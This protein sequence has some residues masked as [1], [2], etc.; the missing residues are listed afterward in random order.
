MIDLKAFQDVFRSLTL[1]V[2]T[3]FLFGGASQSLNAQLGLS[4]ST[5]QHDF[6]RAFES[7]TELMSTRVRM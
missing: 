4:T 5:S 2:T 1:D 6:K 3:E 7:M